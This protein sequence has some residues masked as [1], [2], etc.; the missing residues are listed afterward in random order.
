MSEFDQL[1]KQKIDCK[2][3]ECSAKSWQKFTKKAGW[4][5]GLTGLQITMIAAVSAIVIAV[6]SFVGHK[7]LTHTN[8]SVPTPPTA[9]IPCT[10]DSTLSASSN[11][12]E[13][14]SETDITTPK[15]STVA[16][17][18]SYSIKNES[19]DSKVVTE[20]INETEIIKKDTVS[21]N[22]PIVKRKEY[23]GPIRRVPIIDLDTIKS[24]DF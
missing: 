23:N 9:N 12:I 7:T 18:S 3:Y 11:T 4:K 13:Q 24:N 20:N 17:N 22:K 5:A 15:T 10:T 2:K 6:G 16:S 14:F 8:P 21:N 1:I 19:T